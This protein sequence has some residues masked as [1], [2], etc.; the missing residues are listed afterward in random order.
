MDDVLSRILQKLDDLEAGQKG[1]GVQINEM[2]SQLKSVNARLERLE[3]DMSEVKDRT[4]IIETRIEHDIPNRLDSLADGYK[5]NSE[6]LDG[7]KAVV[8]DID[9]SVTALEVVTKFQN[10]KPITLQIIK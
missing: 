6:K 1:F 8:D 3:A 7:I 9:S 2:G 5:L 4:R 10:D